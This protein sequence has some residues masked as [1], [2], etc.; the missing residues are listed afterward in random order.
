MSAVVAQGARFS[1]TPSGGGGVGKPAAPS[2]FT[3]RVSRIEVEAPTAEVIDATGVRDP[4]SAI[5]LV[6]TGA[7]KGGMIRVDYIADT[8]AGKGVANA[9]SLVGWV[10]QLVFT[11]TGYSI[12]KQCICEAA[13]SS[14]AAGDI[15][16]GSIKFVMTD[17]YG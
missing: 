12:S 16:R 14:A 6:P 3:G 17:W 10:G 13:T 15:I 7:Y 5:V 8:G 1:F 11:A 9:D 2:A 4:S